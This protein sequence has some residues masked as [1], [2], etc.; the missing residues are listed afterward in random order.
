MEQRI[1]NLK[2]AIV[3]D[4][5]TNFGGAEK[6]VQSFLHV[7][8]NADL[9]TTLAT[10]DILK[11]LERKNV[12]TSFL[13]KLPKW[14]R[15]KHQLFLTLL[16]K[17]IECLDLSEYDLVFSSSSFVGKGCLTSPETLHICYCH[18]PTRYLWDT[19][20]EYVAEFPLPRG[21][22]W[23]KIFLPRILSRLRIWDTFASKRP[24]HYISNS[25]FIAR[26]IS[27]YYGRG[28]EVI[29]PPV[30][31]TFFKKG[32]KTSQK[33]HYIAMGRLTPYK[34]FDLLI[35]TFASLPEKR[36]K[37]LGS[38]PDERRLKDLAKKAPNIEFLGFVP[39]TDLP[40]LLGEAKGFLFP[41]I[42]DAGISLMEALA[43][44]TP[45]IAFQKGG[46]LNVIKDGINGIFFAEQN[47]SSLQDALN[48]FE[49]MKFDT[50][51]VQNSVSSFARDTFERRIK[52]F[53]EEKWK[54]F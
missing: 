6:V 4:W 45:A 41:Q 48:R 49:N 52:E 34:R 42:E 50:Q 38:G 2:V 19:W 32:I 8:P 30:N 35:N 53:C 44:G 25:D 43:T 28:S 40:R 36:L 18:T 21:C 47:A 7:F 27:K 11:K 3:A 13:Q 9:F 1:K 24:D 17:A 33:D 37:I 39:Y 46:S 23:I 5:L 31:F 54:E 16:P 26:R 51:K 22:N 10:E 14:I 12:H 29:E 15:K 20:Q